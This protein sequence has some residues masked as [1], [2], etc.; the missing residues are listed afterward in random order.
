[1]D[2]GTLYIMIPHPFRADL[3][4][5]RRVGVSESMC[6]QLRGDADCRTNPRGLEGLVSLAAIDYAYDPEELICGCHIIA[7]TTTSSGDQW[8]IPMASSE[9]NDSDLGGQVRYADR[10]RTMSPEIAN[11]L[12]GE[13]R[14]RNSDPRFD[15]YVAGG[16]AAAAVSPSALAF[17][18]DFDIYITRGSG[19]SEEEGPFVEGE[20]WAKVAE[21][22]DAIRHE[23]TTQRQGLPRPEFI[24]EVVKRG[25]VSF[26]ITRKIQDRT[27]PN[28]CRDETIRVEIILRPYD[29]LSR[30][31]HGFDIAAAS[32][33]Y[34]GGRT[35]LTKMGA[36]AHACRCIFI[37]PEYSSPSYHHR[38][39][40][41]HER[42]FALVI[43]A[44]QGPWVESR[45]VDLPCGL[46]LTPKEVVHGR[47]CYG[48]VT[49]RDPPISDYA[50]EVDF[51]DDDFVTIKKNI[52]MFATRHT[53]TISTLIETRSAHAQQGTPF[54]EYA[55]E[56]VP[57]LRTVLPP[58]VYREGIEALAKAAV[59][60][61]GVNVDILSRV[62]M[63]DHRQISMITSAVLEALDKDPG[64][65]INI[66]ETLH[67]M[68]T[69]MVAR[70]YEIP[71]Q[72]EFW[73][74]KNP[75]S[76]HTGSLNPQPVSLKLFLGEYFCGREPLPGDTPMTICL[77]LFQQR[78]LRLSMP[79]NEE[80][81]FC[82]ERILGRLNVTTFS[83]RHACHFAM[84]S[85][86]GCRGVIG[87]L[88]VLV[89]EGGF[90]LN[91]LHCP[92]CRAPASA[93][94]LRRPVTIP[95]P[96]LE[97]NINIDLLSGND[98]F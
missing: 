13:L 72:L 11:V 89:R 75:A 80:C 83:C 78:T 27:T 95:P 53:V 12:Q 67:P 19:L 42:G 38:L 1:M 36:W 7:P 24:V 37:I 40:K 93:D 81:P 51:A 70:Y 8:C 56:G 33:A 68:V 77:N 10:F 88:E 6:E 48:G 41:Y 73:I 57:S 90:R 64:R 47:V 74:S 34:D 69:A 76:Q 23:Y 61:R 26:T 20:W 29:C 55:T 21:I 9:V 63:L 45:P 94:P 5:L 79:Y 44:F 31:L 50:G 82:D 86:G 4:I 65:Q 49:C 18:G 97:R 3:D 32:V 52:M 17:S 91:G 22:A 46:R 35:F 43:P 62:F 96:R 92:I 14:K 2:A 30:L 98:E 60:K 25:C 28:G 85:G 15:V 66:S 58:H 59:T 71:E 39:R 54:H 87:M 84:T 16:S